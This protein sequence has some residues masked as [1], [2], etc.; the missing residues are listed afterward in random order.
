MSSTPDLFPSPSSLRPDRPF[1]SSG[2]CAKPP[3]WSLGGLEDIFLA[4]RSHRS[5][6]GLSQIR[7][8]LD[9]TR[10]I[11]RLPDDY[12]IAMVPGSATGA[13]EMALW[14][15]LGSRGVDAWGYDVFSGRWLEDIRDRLRLQDARFFEAAP[16]DLPDF[17]ALD[18]E[19]DQVLTWCGTTAGVW[20][21]S[22]GLE[23]P[24]ESRQGLV[25][26]DATSAV[27]A[28]NLPWSSLDVTAF[29]WQKA[30][31]SEAGHG[32]IVLSPRALAY[33]KAYQPPWPVP[34][35]L[36]LQDAAFIHENKQPGSLFKGCTHNTPSMLAVAD[37]L[38]ALHWAK[39]LGGLPALQA[40]MAENNRVME[41][42]VT[43]TP[44]V[45]FLAQKP[46][47]RAPTS[48][49]LT[50]VDP[51][52][53]SLPGSEQWVF[54]QE[55]GAELANEQVAFDCVNHTLSTPSVRF[56]CGPTVEPE[57]LR[58]ALPWVEWAY[59]QVFAKKFFHRT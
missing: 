33:L 43:E 54:M 19:R 37:C 2:P 34:R 13:M 55:I 49:C 31:G 38:Y 51:L 59:K 16:G 46:E 21:E 56:W 8:L 30:L 44:W 32:M 6:P 4:G 57:D 23:P 7:E 48:V 22:V 17:S 45:K 25:L 36:D 47:I 58:R 3:G 27:F 5:A 52:F 26:C 35:L 41:A 12:Q 50:I 9:L 42:W 15:F 14:N 11:L 24:L 53:V 28:A 1:F 10:D 20:L 29:S 18:P 39:N 40:R